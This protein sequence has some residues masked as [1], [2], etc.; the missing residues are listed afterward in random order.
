MKLVPDNPACEI[1]GRPATVE[2]HD[3]ST[4][5]DHLFC[6]AHKPDLWPGRNRHLELRRYRSEPGSI[7]SQFMAAPE[8]SAEHQSFRTE[9]CDLQLLGGEGACRYYLSRLTGSDQFALWQ[10]EFLDNAREYVVAKTNGA[11]ACFP[12]DA[13]TIGSMAPF[14]KDAFERSESSVEPKQSKR[15][16]AVVLLLHHPSW[17][18]ERIA[19]E[20]PTTI[21]QLQRNSN[22]RCLSASLI[23][24][25]RA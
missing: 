6:P 12:F 17:S 22:Y 19:K 9:M 13:G 8:E 14:F 1:C 15:D 4:D 7:V 10:T 2:L 18:D 21:K 5:D 24:N 16:L 20:A 25:S 3:T 23:R 11:A